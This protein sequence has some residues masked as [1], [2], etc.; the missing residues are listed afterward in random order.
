MVRETAWLLVISGALAA[1]SIAARPERWGVHVA[2]ALANLGV[3]AVLGRSRSARWRPQATPWLLVP[4]FVSLGVSTWTAGPL[5]LMNGPFYVLVLAWMGLH[6]PA[7]IILRAAPAV[8]VTYALGMT[9]AGFPVGMGLGGILL[10]FPIATLVGLVIAHQVGQLHTAQEALRAEE[11]WR[12]AM[13]ATLAHDVR[14]PL[15]SVSGALEIIADDPG[16][17]ARHLPLIA[18]AARQAERI[19]RLATGLLEV[20]RIDQGRLQLDHHD[21]RLAELALEVAEAVGSP[22]VF[23]DVDPGI[24]VW[25]D[26]ERLEQIL[27]NL[28]S[29]ALRHGLPPVVVTARS[30]PT[31][32]WV[33]VRDHGP[34]IPPEASE[35]LFDRLNPSDAP[36]SVGL[37]LWIVR[38]LAEAH[39]GTVEHRPAAPGTEF[40][41]R[42]PSGHDRPGEMLQDPHRQLPTPVVL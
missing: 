10:L 35:H 29:N 3:A 14:S 41:V 18:G 16:T 42:L 30:T 25:A 19:R 22:G 39:G 24:E 13:V 34:G 11:R 33:S 7:R 28:V 36:H 20:E 6:L 40:L 8:A 4:V 21:V 9:A 31:E 26:R 2:I 38:L 5:A 1:M 17:P 23:V 37:G 15:T 32:S 27:T 12:A